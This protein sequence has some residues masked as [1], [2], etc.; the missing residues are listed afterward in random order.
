[1]SDDFR[2]TR[3]LA[4]ESG[5]PETRF[6]FYPEA[7]ELVLGTISRGVLFLFAYWSGPAHMAFKRLSQVVGNLDPNGRLDFVVVDIDGARRI[8]ELPDFRGIVHGNGE[9]AWILDGRIQAV[10]AARPPTDS[11]HHYEQ[12]TRQLL[13]D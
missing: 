8:C 5:L 10:S 2:T 7:D 11:S 6:R 9:A 13:L 4:E 1:M 12:F 3:W